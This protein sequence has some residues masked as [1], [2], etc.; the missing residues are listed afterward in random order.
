MTHKQC[1]LDYIHCI[2]EKAEAVA[3]NEDERAG[4]GDFD[5]GKEFIGEGIINHSQ[6]VS[7]TALHKTCGAG[8]GPENEKVYRNKLKARIMH[9]F[10]DNLQKWKVIVLAIARLKE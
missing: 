10:F 2:L 7:M 9:N 6:A 3:D 1:Y 5:K 4:F 8:I